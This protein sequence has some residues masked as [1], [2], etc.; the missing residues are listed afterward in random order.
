VEAELA[1]IGYRAQFLE[2]GERELISFVQ[3][4]DYAPPNGMSEHS[5]DFVIPISQSFVPL[6]Q[7]DISLDA[8]LDV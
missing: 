8:Y 1:V 2:L 7:K 5:V 6:L 4:F 3:A